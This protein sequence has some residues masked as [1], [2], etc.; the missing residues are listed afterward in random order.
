[1]QRRTRQELYRAFIIFVSSD[2]KREQQAVNRRMFSVL[3]WCLLLPAFFAFVVLLLVKFGVL[4]LSTKRYLDWFIWLFPVAYS[5]YYLGAEVIAEGY[6]A[7]KQSGVALSLL[8]STKAGQWRERV[9]DGLKQNIDATPEE[10]EWIVAS[11]QIDLRE[12][13]NRNRYLTILSGAVFYLLMEGIDLVAEL[14]DPITISKHPVLGWV[15][16]TSE[17]HLPP[18]PDYSQFLG[19]GL[20]L[21][22]FYLSGSQTYH[23]LRRYLHCAMLL[24]NPSSLGTERLKG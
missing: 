20:F 11:F 17:G 4:P 23:P 10:W 6:N 8:Q 16:T 24:K 9:C 1:M 5:L 19:L 14:G 22:L 15:Q 21:V 13:Q 7:L 12:M 3:L 18:G 2:S